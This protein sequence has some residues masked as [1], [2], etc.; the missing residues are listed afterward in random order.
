M[1]E[2]T[3]AVVSKPCMPSAKDNNP[4]IAS[5]VST[6]TDRV[7]GEEEA[8]SAACNDIKEDDCVIKNDKLCVANNQQETGGSTADT[9]PGGTEALLTNGELLG[10]HNARGTEHSDPSPI[11]ALETSP[12]VRLN[13]KH[14]LYADKKALRWSLFALRIA[15]MTEG[16]SHTY[17]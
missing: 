17:V 11:S 1:P 15:V 12:V 4:E 3:A 6:S 13:D 14:R 7:K 10:N 9:A 5:A 8:R 16:A 2:T